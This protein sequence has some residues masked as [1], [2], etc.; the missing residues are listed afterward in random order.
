VPGMSDAQWLTYKEL[1]AE[2]GL[3]VRAAEA[4]ARR[5]VKAGRW[6]HRIDNDTGAGR[7]LVT[8]AELDAMRQYAPG[9]APPALPD[10]LPPAQPG[11]LPVPGMDPSTVSALLAEVQAA[12][13]QVAGELREAADELRRR[14]E[15]AEVEAVTLRDALV[16]ERARADAA[17]AEREQARVQ[18][19]A[20]EGE[21]K[22]LRLAL[23]EARRPFW[24]RWL[25]P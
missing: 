3:T 12:H 24:R 1:A 14:A 2:T 6:R 19:A 8:Q 10:T 5:Q 22:G 15:R 16:Q 17:A 20:A 21:A 7:V 4:R 11:A 18:A 13:E 9:G 25:G 23:E